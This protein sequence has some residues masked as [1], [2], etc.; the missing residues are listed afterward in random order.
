MNLQRHVWNVG[1]Q[2][3]VKNCVV[4]ISPVS[5]AFQ[6]PAGV[7][8]AKME[9]SKGKALRHGVMYFQSF[10]L[11]ILG[12][13]LQRF[14]NKMIVFICDTSIQNMPIFYFNTCFVH[15]QLFKMIRM[16]LSKK[17]LKMR[18]GNKRQLKIYEMKINYQCYH[19][20]NL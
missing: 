9:F 16:D 10:N 11:I 4:S 14:Y 20:H 1:K 19:K 7:R 17:K 6:V 5:F 12:L 15:I 2:K 18:K 8:T 13:D 3:R